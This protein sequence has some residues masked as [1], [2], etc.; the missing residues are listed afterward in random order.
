MAQTS[1][2]KQT[3]SNGQP[4]TS[5]PASQAAIVG[6]DHDQPSGLPPTPALEDAL[7][8]GIQPNAEKPPV[9]IDLDDALGDEQALK[10]DVLEHEPPPI[11]VRAPR[12]RE[13]IMVHP[14]YCRTVMVV[15]YQAPDGIGRAYYL[16][17][18]SMRRKLEEED[19]KIVNLVPCISLTD[20]ALF[21]W[22]M[23][24][25]DVGTEN[26]WNSSSRTFAEN[27]KRYWARR[28]SHKKSGGTGYG[29]RYAP[30][31][32]EPAKWPA[33]TLKEW[34][35]DAFKDRILA[36]EDHP[37]YRDIQGHLA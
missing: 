23:N 30:E 31:G 13:F 10:H 24:V 25:D 3:S 8:D 34:I 32:K 14:T 16:A 15:E 18:S 9:A 7:G 17:T 35:A 12:K 5:A 36:T 11:E 27:A 37:V 6:A 19:L 28:V 26:L 4:R 29:T 21:L 22:P 2:K 1:A 33:G 20:H